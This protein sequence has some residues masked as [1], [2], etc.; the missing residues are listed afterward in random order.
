MSAEKKQRVMPKGGRTGGTI[1]PRVALADAIVFAKR[2]VSKT[3]VNPQ[4][5]DV[6]MA[7]VVQAKGPTAE[8]KISAMKQYGFLEGDSKNLYSASSLAK[9]VAHATPDEL[10]I[11][12]RE[13]A[14]GP[15][16]FKQIFE[17]YHGDTV[18]K[19]KLK[20]R[21]ADL[22]VHPDKTTTCIN[23]YIASMS[24]AGLIS[25][26]GEKISHLSTASLEATEN[27]SPELGPYLNN[28]S[29][30]NGN[31]TQNSTNAED[32]I[33][34]PDLQGNLEQGLQMPAGTLPP[35]AIFN[36]NVNLD[37]SMDIEKLSK[38]LELLKK[39]GA[40]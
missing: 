4:S 26:D 10:K 1:F 13:A 16:V 38:Q 19:A 9:K 6:I 11:Y 31:G 23:L 21:A 33:S 12:C 20:Q 40:I 2:L 8:I 34:K 37:S 27:Q 3:H 18:T 5:R 36:I 15:K 22:K 39:F 30:E 25:V 28:E 29:I 7:G 24:E 14:M 17:T 35:R 32:E